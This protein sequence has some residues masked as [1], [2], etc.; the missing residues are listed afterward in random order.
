[1]TTTGK[2][3]DKAKKMADAAAVKAIEINVR[4]DG[5]SGL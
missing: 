5:H 3:L 2:L 1:M 4:P